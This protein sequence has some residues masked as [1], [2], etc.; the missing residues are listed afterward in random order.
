M[1]RTRVDVTNYN[2]PMSLPLCG[3]WGDELPYWYWKVCLCVDA[4][5][6]RQD[7]VVK[8]RVTVQS[9]FVMVSTSPSAATIDCFV[10]GQHQELAAKR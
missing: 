2:G 8:L 4:N 10:A 7:V 5:L 6:Q 3:R 1:A 9:P